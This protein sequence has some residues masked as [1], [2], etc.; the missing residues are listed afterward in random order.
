[1]SC[2]PLEAN[3]VR[4]ARSQ[5]RAARCQCG[6]RNSN[7]FCFFFFFLFSLWPSPCRLCV[8]GASLGRSR[9]FPLDGL[10]SFLL[11]G[12]QV[13][14]W[15]SREFPLV[16]PASCLLWRSREFPLVSPP[17]ILMACIADYFDLVLTGQDVGLGLYG[18]EQRRS[19]DQA[20]RRIKDKPCVGQWART[21]S[22]NG[23]SPASD[24]GPSPTPHKGQAQHRTTEQA[25]RRI[26]DKLSASLQTDKNST[27]Q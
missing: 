7:T 10:A 11:W 14:S 27:G 16:R 24:N 18:Q 6:A 26:T 20:R 13:S 3:V 23:P 8:I 15:R 5:V 9:E 22:A 25:Q 17:S 1:M 21:A 4:A 12:P 2:V 19:T